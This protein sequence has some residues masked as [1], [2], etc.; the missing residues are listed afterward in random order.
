MLPLN[1]LLSISVTGGI[2]G[3]FVAAEWLILS[4][5]FAEDTPSK[6]VKTFN[7]CYITRA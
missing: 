2:E 7:M 4:R 6:K 3:E 1:A 5:Y